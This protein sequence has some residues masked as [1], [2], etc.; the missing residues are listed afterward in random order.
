MGKDLNIV[1]VIGN[2][3]RDPEI[4]F[5]SAGTPVTK[6]SIANNYTFKQG[7]EIKEE[8]NFFDIVVWSNQAVNCEKYLKKG[9]KV[10]VTGMLRQNRWTDETTQQ[11]RSKVEI[12]ANTVQFL[13]PVQGGSVPATNADQSYTP[14]NNGDDSIPF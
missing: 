11:G 5:T 6:M 10:A 9:S 12:V 8:V 3:V 7:E 1:S 4:K 14:Q 13:T 2:L